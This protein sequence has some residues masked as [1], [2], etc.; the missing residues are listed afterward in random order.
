MAKQFYLCD[1]VGGGTE[2]DPFR[3]AVADHGVNHVAVFPP[4]NQGSSVLV[5]V[6]TV[7]HN[8]LRGDPRID[9]LPEFPLEG[10]L[11]ALRTETRTEVENAISRRGFD[12]PWSNSDAYRDVIRSIGQQLDSHFDENNFD[13]SE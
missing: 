5:L 9:P 12:Q 3:A 10:K 2:F 13:V 6:A 1:L 8:V 4:N 11:S 7:N